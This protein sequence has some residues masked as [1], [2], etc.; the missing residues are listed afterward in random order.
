M[1]ALRISFALLFLGAGVLGL[2]ARSAAVADA[3]GQVAPVGQVA[4][5]GQV[6]PPEQAAPAAPAEAPAPQPAAAPAPAAT[7]AP[8]AAAS[9]PL[10]IKPAQPGGVPMIT[11]NFADTVDVRVLAKWVSEVTNQTF[12]YD[13]SF[14]GT[15]M[16]EAPK[17][18]PESSLLP[19]FESILKLKGFAMVQQGDLV[20]IVKS[21]AAPALI[22][23]GIT[24]R[25][26]IHSSSN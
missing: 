5:A 24:A 18:V 21:T 26:C 14:Q 8:P 1:N 13:D 10:T 11:L 4:P 2:P 15:V 3:S 19:L 9:A 16:L 22:T 25:L 17:E 6:A 20:M 7:P 23:I 12:A